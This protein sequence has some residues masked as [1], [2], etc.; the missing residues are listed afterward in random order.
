MGS[1]N[2][3][4]AIGTSQGLSD[5]AA[6]LLV[7]MAWHSLDAPKGNMPAR[8]YARGWEHAAT[9]VWG[10]LSPRSAND[11]VKRAMAEL[12]TAGRV[13]PLGVAARG[14]RQTYELLT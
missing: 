8:V 1:R 7:F 2:V 5:R 14:H 13:K 12:T 9:L 10:D 3:E 11:K 4:W 6:R